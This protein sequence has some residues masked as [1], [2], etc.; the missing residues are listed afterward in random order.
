MALSS[1]FLASQIAARSLKAT[2]CDGSMRIASVKSAIALSKSLLKKA[3]SPLATRALARQ[4]GNCEI[5]MTVPTPK[6]IAIS[7]RPTPPT[8]HKGLR[9]DLPSGRGGGLRL[10][11]PNAMQAAPPAPSRKQIRIAASLYAM[12]A[13][14][15]YDVVKRP[16]AIRAGRPSATSSSRCAPRLWTRR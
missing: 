5:T 14:L 8:T 15:P 6:T 13:D 16:S 11:T 12:C 1:S 3:V 4:C 9:A 7:S 2:A 10:L